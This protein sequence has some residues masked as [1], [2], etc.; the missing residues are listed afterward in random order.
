MSFFSPCVLPIIPLYAAYLSGGAIKHDEYGNIVYP[1]KTIIVNTLF[2]VTGIGF[3]FFL[4]G[5]GFTAAGHFFTSNRLWLVRISGIIMILF[6]MYQAGLFGQNRLLMSEHRF[7]LQQNKAMGPIT[8]L[9]TG[10]TFSFAWTPCVG[11]ILSGVLLMAASS[12]TSA[13]GFILIGV[14]TLGFVIPFVL[15]GLFT[16]QVLSFLRKHKNGVKYTIKAGA[17]IL[18]AMGIITL[19]GITANSGTVNN[20]A[21]AVGEKSEVNNA[22][23]NENQPSEA[24]KSSEDKAASSQS[25]EGKKVIPAPDFELTD[26]FGN[27]HKLSD[28]KGKTVFLNFW[29]TWCTFCKSEMPEIQA[30]Y[31]KYGK[32]QDDLI[33]IGVAA[34]NSGREGDSEYIKNFLAKNGYDFPVVFDETGDIFRNYGVSSF[35]TT[36]MISPDTSVFGYVAGALNADGMESI[37]SQTMSGKRN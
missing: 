7:N 27:K 24:A 19:M 14:Y 31:E 28:Y 4:L 2:F 10:F 20:T 15:M 33:V 3:A 23:K 32:N 6:G 9:I 16:G 25:T 35:P 36:F 26:Q 11:P 30:L 5:F 21:A 13:K 34:P 12:D 18:I 8:A 29:A 1:K 17:F 37:V 22:D